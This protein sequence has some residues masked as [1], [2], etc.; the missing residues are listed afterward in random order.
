MPLLAICMEYC[1]AVLA[2]SGSEGDFSQRHYVVVLLVQV[3]QSLQCPSFVMSSSN[4]HL[5]H[6]DVPIYM[7]AGLFGRAANRKSSTSDS[8]LA[9]AL[10]NGLP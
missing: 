8:S 1:N 3:S 4:F 7:T 6:D 10:D 2:P 9:L 5:G